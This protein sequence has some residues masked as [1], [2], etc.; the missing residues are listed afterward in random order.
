[1]TPIQVIFCQMFSGIF[2]LVDCDICF[3]LLSWIVFQKNA[4]FSKANSITLRLPNSAETRCSVK[5]IRRQ[6][7]YSQT[8]IHSGR[9]ESLSRWLTLFFPFVDQVTGTNLSGTVEFGLG[10]K[11]LLLNGRVDQL[12]VITWTKAPNAFYSKHNMHGQVKACRWEFN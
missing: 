4:F 6:W 10:V 3:W 9:V 2:H 5:F 1:M 8:L 11:S 12:F 7:T